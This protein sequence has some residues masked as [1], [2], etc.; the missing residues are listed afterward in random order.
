MSTKRQN[1]T[2][3]EPVALRPSQLDGTATTFSRYERGNASKDPSTI[4][5]V[6]SDRSVEKQ[7]HPMNNVFREDIWGKRPFTVL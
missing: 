2:F 3:V 5:H 6:E 4:W 7:P 1:F